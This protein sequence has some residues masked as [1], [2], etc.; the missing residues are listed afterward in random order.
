MLLL[1]V[2]PFAMRAKAKGKVENGRLYS[3]I[4]QYSKRL[5]E[6]LKMAN[7]YFKPCLHLHS[8]HWQKTMRQRYHCIHLYRLYLKMKKVEQ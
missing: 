1:A 8:A 5:P 4:H 3:I 6:I 7:I 2:N